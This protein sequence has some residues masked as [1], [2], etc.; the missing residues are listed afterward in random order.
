MGGAN[1]AG[2]AD[3]LGQ[4]TSYGWDGYNDLNQFYLGFPTYYRDY[5]REGHTVATE[6]TMYAT[7]DNLWKVGTEHGLT[8]VDKNGNS[9]DANFVK[10]SFKDD[11]P[12]SARP[13]SQTVHLEFWSDQP[14]Y[15]VDWKYDPK[16]NMYLRSNGGQ[17]HIDK[18]TNKQLSA[19]NIAV[20]YMGQQ[21]APDGY[22]NNEHLLFQDIGTGKAVVFMD[23]KEINGTWSKKSRTGRTVL[24]DANGNPIKFDRGQIWFEVLPVETGVVTVK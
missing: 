2:P 1:A 7:P 20:L 9:W 19:K 21:H 11:A 16:T 4:I 14:D 17:P 23:G 3:A 18:D 6:H 10:Y 22:E 15:N 13:A 8:N 5:T 12:A 24:Y